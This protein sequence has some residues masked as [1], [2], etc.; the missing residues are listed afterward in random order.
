MKVLLKFDGQQP[1][2]VAAELVDGHPVAWYYR[3]VPW[4]AA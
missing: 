2:L 3:D 1:E 4:K